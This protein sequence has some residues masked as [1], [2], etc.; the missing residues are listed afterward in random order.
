MTQHD[1]PAVS[2]DMIQCSISDSFQQWMSQAGGSLVVT[3][4][5]AGKVAMIGW[6]GRQV[7]LL[8]RQFDKPM[9][10]AISGSKMALATRHDVILLSDAKLLAPDYLEAQRGRYDS[11]YLPRASF[12][13]GDINVHDMAY[14]ADGLWLV[15]TRFCCLA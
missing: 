10:L 2:G 12:H 4:Y 9:G 5:Q 11:L 15:N 1:R 6:D 14:G 3:T 8:M 7:T 13:T